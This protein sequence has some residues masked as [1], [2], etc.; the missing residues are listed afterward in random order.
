ML[1][2]LK[3]FEDGKEHNTKECKEIAI[4][5]LGLNEVD[6]KEL[7]PS[8]KQ[9]LVENRVYWSLTYLKKSILIESV[10]RRSIQYHR[11]RKRAFKKQTR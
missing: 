7:V 1:P 2:I 10:N 6:I 3:L 4:K 11:K 5:E 8:G 9:T